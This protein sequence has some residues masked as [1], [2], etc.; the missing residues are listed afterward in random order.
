MALTVT[1]QTG[2][3]LLAI[4]AHAAI[5][6]IAIQK[7]KKEDKTIY[8]VIYGGLVWLNEDTY[9]EEKNPIEGFNYFFELDVNPKKNHYNI[10]KQCYMHLKKQ[11]EFK[12]ALDS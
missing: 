5:K 2:M 9:N 10:W 6:E 7:E 4:D 11:K 12:D 1:V 8:R 3:G